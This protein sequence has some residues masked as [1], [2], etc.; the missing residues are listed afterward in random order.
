MGK[1]RFPLI[2]LTCKGYS[3]KFFVYE[4]FKRIGKE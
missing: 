4:A 1:G 3:S 2:V